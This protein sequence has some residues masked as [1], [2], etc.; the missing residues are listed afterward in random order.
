MRM[1]DSL[2]RSAPVRLAA[3][4]FVLLG[5]SPGWAQESAPT[6][7]DDG[8]GAEM[9]DVT[10]LPALTVKGDRME[11][12]GV[13][14]N[15]Q[16]GI[17]TSI[18]QLSVAEVFPNTAAAKAGLRPGERVEKIDGKSVGLRTLVSIG[19]KPQKLQERMWADLARGKK[20]V[21]LTLEVRAPEA[22][23]S[24]TVTLT[25]PSPPPRWG[26]EH[27]SPPEGRTPAL[28]REPGPLAA[29]AREVLD[30][31]IWSGRYDRA[32]YE[33]R[34]V[35]PTGGH[36]IW[37][38]QQ[39]GKTEIRL[40]HR[41]DESV[42][43]GFTTS[44]AGAMESASGRPPKKHKDRVIS[45]EELRARFEAEIDFW[46]HHVGRVTGRWP[47]EALSGETAV[48]TSTERRSFGSSIAKPAGSEAGKSGAPLAESF[49]KLPVATAE[50][51]RL[52]SDALGK[53]GRDADCWAFSETAR[54]L[55]D[56]HAT[57]V[58]FDPSQPPE[59]RSTLLK[60]DGKA[61]K[62][63]YL[64]KWRDEGRGAL[65]GL[66]DLPP[67]SSVVDLDDV[68]VYAEETAAVVFELPVKASNPDFP[69]DK[70]QARFRVN[71]TH[72][73]F[74]DFSVKLRDPMRMAGIAKV[75]EAGLEA[76]FQTPD[77]ALAPQPVFL[78]MGGGVRVLLVK[79][80]RAFEVTRTDFSRVIPYE[81]HGQPTL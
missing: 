61:P 3:C 69:A 39:R 73:G 65:P 48:I 29:L 5:G 35:Q 7:T 14:F 58:R 32:G 74:E 36:R 27:W 71:K 30:N 44:P 4:W 23:E 43:C 25:L 26:S 37:V 60:V 81:E 55:D 49:L 47:F 62:A 64:K 34:I 21:S 68:R 46:L 12:L 38:S 11:D 72:R 54:T 51:K 76:R 33:W 59:A 42:F 50:Q 20:S 75:T 16:V 56:D 45:A 28:V 17:P 40:E 13:R 1:L 2:I 15:V 66:G 6:P 10:I 57:T 70:F 77:P 8:R 67:L 22:K 31:G 52:F 9:E 18:N 79:L 53:I 24:R 41:S 19:F 78:K 80:S 63:A